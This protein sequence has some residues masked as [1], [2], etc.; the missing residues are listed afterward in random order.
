MELGAVGPGGAKVLGADPWASGQDP[1]TTVGA[2]GK[3]MTPP[4][5][6]TSAPAAGLPQSE[7]DLLQ[8]QLLAVRTELAAFTGG[9][10][11]QQPGGQQ[12][13][14]CGGFGHKRDNCPNKGKGKGKPWGSKGN[15]KGKSGP[16]RPDWAICRD[17]QKNGTCAH[18]EKWGWCKFAHV[19][20]PAGPLQAIEGLVL[21]DFTKR[22]AVRYLP[23]EECWECIADRA[24]ADLATIVAQELETLGELAEY[25]PPEAPNLDL[26]LSPEA[27]QGFQGQPGRYA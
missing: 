10:G 5:S 1:W 4:V 3:P 13:Y 14:A 19:K 16:V 27:Q 24:P 17:V 26:W 6:G 23:K 11:G 9:K 21:E 12:C 20:V 8:Q 22:N 7:A 15:G 25:D 18:K 2:N